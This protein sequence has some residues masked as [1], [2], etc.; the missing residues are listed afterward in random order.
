MPGS[1]S[2]PNVSE[3]YEVPTELPGSTGCLRLVNNRCIIY[4]FYDGTII[5]LVT[6]TMQV[7]ILYNTVL[8]SIVRCSSFAVVE[9]SSTASS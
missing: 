5:M 8:G 9:D 4:I 6:T 2:R 7:H 3:G 1:N